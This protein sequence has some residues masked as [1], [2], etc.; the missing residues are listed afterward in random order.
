MT[1]YIDEDF[2]SGS[3]ETDLAAGN[4]SFD[5]F[6]A[7]VPK[8]DSAHAFA[9]SLSMRA[10][11]S[12]TVGYVTKT[13]TATNTAY[14][15]FYVLI[16]SLPAA[17]LYLGTLVSG[18]TIRAQCAI[19]TTGQVRLRDAT[20]S[21]YTSTETLSTGV[22]YR[23]E[24]DLVSG[25]SQ[26]VRAY[27][28][29]STTPL[30]DSGADTYTSGTFDGLRFGNT[31]TATHSVWFDELAVDDTANPGPLVTT[32]AL[33]Q[34]AETD[35]AAAVDVVKVADPGQSAGIEAAAELATSKATAPGAASTVGAAGAATP[36]KV[37]HVPSQHDAVFDEAVFDQAVFDG[38]TIPA[39]LATAGPVT[40]VKT[41]A[42]GVA[43]EPGTAAAVAVVK[44]FAA[45]TASGTSSAGQVTAVVVVPVGAASET[46][47]AAQV[48]VTE[49]F[50]PGTASETT[51]TIAL[52][53]VK[54]V[55]AAAAAEIG[56]ASAAS[57]VKT[58]PVGVAAETDSAASVSTSAVVVSAASESSSAGP[59]AVARVKVTGA[60]AEAATAGAVTAGKTA[61]VGAATG[62]GSA[63]PV[64]AVK[65]SPVGPATATATAYPLAAARTVTL[66]AA[67]TTGTALPVAAVRVVP[68]GAAVE[69]DAAGP[70]T[71]GSTVVGMASST[72]TATAVVAV[73][74]AVR[75]AGYEGQTNGTA[76]TSANSDDYGDSAL[77]SVYAGP[78]G[79]I[80]YSTAQAIGGSVSLEMAQPTASTPCIAKYRMGTADFTACA[81]RIYI[82]LTD[83][84]SADTAF[85]VQVQTN[86][87]VAVFRVQLRAT[88]VL[89]LLDTAGTAVAE[90][91]ATM[92]AGAWYRIEVQASALNGSNTVLALQLFDRDS[93]SPVSGGSISA[94]SVTTTGSGRLI[95]LGKTT[96]ATLGTRWFDDVRAV[97]G[98]SA[99]IG[100]VARS[101]V[102]AV[103][104][105]G[106]TGTATAVTAAKTATVGAASQTET[107]LP[108]GAVV[109]VA[110]GTAAEQG[111][112]GPVAAVRVAAVTSG[113]ETAAAA[114]VS[115]V[116]AVAAAVGGETGTAYPVTT[117][118]GTTVHVGVAT[119][120]AAASAFARLLKTAAAQPAQETS[121]AR[122]VTVG[123]PTVL[124]DLG[125]AYATDLARPVTGTVLPSIGG[126]MYAQATHTVTVRR[127][128]TTDTFG[129]TVDSGTTIATGVQVSIL[130]RTKRVFVPADGRWEQ[131]RYYA[132]RF[133]ALSGVRA[134]D[135]IEDEATGY[136][137]VIDDVDVSDTLVTTHDLRCDLRR[138]T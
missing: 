109:V 76:A 89:R 54:T 11:T 66:G 10:T 135:Q 95:V 101:A 12:A 87:G 117:R 82:R 128:T 75:Q 62:T 27:E 57:V 106:E 137:Y 111:Q 70:V 53:T 49:R 77:D 46:T 116:K 130:E 3:D 5:S 69:S 7:T 92:T 60:A 25:S 115:V 74:G 17:T 122:P 63:G 79:T 36:V 4:S 86:G 2:E 59:V 15:R 41:A 133:P 52:A 8:F 18:T 37:V 125:A 97:S 71:T 38:Q 43:A 6:T 134:G 22:W 124:V 123:G 51:A 73:Q 72:E 83:L 65:V 26:A 20:T 56:T 129:D 99:A 85:P 9:G 68:V 45:G 80:A 104:V 32:A 33:G 121:T 19:T 105:A 64:A 119:S 34:S 47:A 31:A 58:V 113:T 39:T 14:I 114:P 112:A 28:G 24:W 98:S 55:P 16:E 13:W 42:V 35:A 100:P 84:P 126:L 1:L 96:T 29:N 108:V 127:G 132:A 50:V 61:P 103:G 102:E 120:A 30:L 131:V 81:I 67:T 23:I 94:S 93:T 48:A 88:G 138:V 118:S 110:L 136:D 90:T 40:P 107:G 78:G 44:A 91:T 21:V